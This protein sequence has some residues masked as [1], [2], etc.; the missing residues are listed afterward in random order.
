M[1]EMYELNL[2]VIR[3]CGATSI[4]NWNIPSYTDCVY[5]G[6]PIDLCRGIERVNEGTNNLFQENEM[7]ESG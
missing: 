2:G 5:H 1:Q 4:N 7:F 6:E 3:G